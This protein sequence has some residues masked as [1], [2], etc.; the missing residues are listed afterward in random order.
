METKRMYE[1]VAEKIIAQLKEGTAPW[2]KPWDS[3]G[4][5]FTLPYNAVTSKPYRGLNSLYLHLFSPFSDPRWSTFKQA[6]SQ[7][8]TVKKGSKGMPINFVKTHDL[9]PKRDNA[10]RPL[11]DEKGKP[12]KVRVQLDKPLVTKAWV[13][14]AEQIAGIPELEK[15]EEVNLW[16]KV[17]RAEEIVRQSQA[18]IEHVAGNMA[19]YSPTLDRIKMP[20]REQFQTSDRYYA[21][22]LHEL[23]H[24]TGHPERLNRSLANGF[25]SE[26]YAKEELRAEIASMMVGA[27]L[28]LGHDPGQHVAYVNSWIQ[29]LTDTPF[30]IHAAAADAQRIFDYVL[31]FEN[32]E[33]KQEQLNSRQTSQSQDGRENTYVGEKS[34]VREM[35]IGR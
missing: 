25:G 29:I 26:D 19:S 7:G 17:E 4:N 9:I 2:Q 24:W 10:G 15:K 1:A 31:A 21:T 30:E 12:I 11:K 32:R 13:F 34:G 16:E 14:N 33:L 23:G 5:D 8:W 27:E 3:A 6:A 22:L 35:R 18:K 20:L 28:K